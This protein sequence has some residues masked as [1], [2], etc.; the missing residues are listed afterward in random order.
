MFRSENWEICS[1]VKPSGGKIAGIRTTLLLTLDCVG[2][3]LLSFRRF[4]FWEPARGM[5]V[6]GQ[7]G[8]K[9]DVMISESNCTESY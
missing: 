8:S 6:S 2:I 1:G 7:R 3:A 9:D 5:R 4:E